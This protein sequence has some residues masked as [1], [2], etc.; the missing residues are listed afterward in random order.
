MERAAAAN[1][2]RATNGE[3]VIPESKTNQAIPNSP[4]GIVAR[5]DVRI[6]V[7]VFIT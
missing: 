6:E 4:N 3:T 2:N 1:R 7:L 5:S